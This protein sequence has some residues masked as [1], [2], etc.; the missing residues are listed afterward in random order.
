M[1]TDSRYVICDVKVL[2]S[3][4]KVSNSFSAGVD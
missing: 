3:L 1:P 4:D 2:L